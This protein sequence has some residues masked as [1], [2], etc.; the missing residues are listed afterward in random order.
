M[1]LP[2]GV[3]KEIAKADANDVRCESSPGSGDA[4]AGLIF[5]QH[6]EMKRL[7]ASTDPIFKTAEEAVAKMETE[8]DEARTNASFKLV[9]EKVAEPK[10]KKKKKGGKKDGMQKQEEEKGEEG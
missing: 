10:P 6:G 9:E 5:L 8:V 7:V 4:H 2:H 1:G 3:A